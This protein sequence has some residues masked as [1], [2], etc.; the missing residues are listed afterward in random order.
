MMTGHGGR[1]CSNTR[2]TKAGM[3]KARGQPGLCGEINN[4]LNDHSKSPSA[5]MKRWCPVGLEVGSSLGVWRLSL[6]P[7]C[8]TS[9]A[10]VTKNLVEIRL[11]VYSGSQVLRIRSLMTEK[12]Q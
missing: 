4:H 12:A 2:E 1:C 10:A 8:V 7:L 3:W 6:V 11:R 9:L 5:N